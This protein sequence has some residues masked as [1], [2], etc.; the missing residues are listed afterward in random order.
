MSV[1]SDAIARKLSDRPGCHTK[2]QYLDEA[3]ARSAGS[4]MQGK[5]RTP[6][7]TYRCAYCSTAE[8]PVWHIGRPGR[9]KGGRR[10]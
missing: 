3:D 8:R 10:G 7:S 2:R 6:F 1:I 4:R 9:S 5:H